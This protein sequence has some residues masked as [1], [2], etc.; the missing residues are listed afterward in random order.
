MGKEPPVSLLRH[1]YYNLYKVYQYIGIPCIGYNRG[2]VK[3]ILEALFP[4]GLVEPNDDKA[5]LNKTLAILDGDGIEIKENTEFLTSHMCNQTI[6][7]YK[8]ISS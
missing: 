3:E 4:Y 1:P 5:I 7:F 6:E 8:E 2:G